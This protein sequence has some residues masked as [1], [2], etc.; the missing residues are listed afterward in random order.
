M[1][2]VVS[3]RLLIMALALALAP[4]VAVATDPP[5]R[6]ADYPAPIHV[7]SLDELRDLLEAGDIDEDQYDTL[8]DLLESP[9][10]LNGATR[11]ELYDL[12]GLTYS[13]VDV[14]IRFR[15]T[16]GPVVDVSDLGQ[17]G[18]P[19]SVIGQIRSFVRGKVVPPAEKPPIK[20]QANL[21]T[22]TPLAQ[23]A[24]PSFSLKLRADV[25]DWV[26]VGG[27]A[28]LQDWIGPF[29]VHEDPG[30][31]WISAAAPDY[32]FLVPKFFAAVQQPQWGVV[33]GTYQV[34]FA[35][36]L[37]VGDST[38][39]HPNG[40]YPDVEVPE[41]EEGERFSPRERL[42]GVAASLKPLQLGEA[43]AIE[44]TVFLSWWPYD[45]NQNDVASERRLDDDTGTFSN[46]TDKTPNPLVCDAGADPARCAHF[47]SDAE[48][49]ANPD[50]CGS[51][52]AG[53]L[54]AQRLR[55]AYTELAFGGHVAYTP[56]P[57]LRIGVSSMTSF[58]DW[59]GWRDSGD[60]DFTP[61]A[62]YPA[63]RDL[64][65][66]FGVD[67]L[68]RF[69][70]VSI[71]G[72][73]AHT[74]VGGNAAVL[75]ANVGFPS[76]D[77]ELIGRY[78]QDSFDNPHARG[79]AQSDEYQGQRDR[80]EAGGRVRVTAYPLPW[81]DA[82]L[83]LDVWHRMSLATTNLSLDGKLYL[84]PLEWLSIMTSVGYVDRDLTAGGRDEVYDRSDEVRDEDADIDE[85]EIDPEIAASAYDTTVPGGRGSKVAARLRL[86]FNPARWLRLEAGYRATFFDQ[87]VTLKAT[88]YPEAE[89]NDLH[90]F[91][92]K[93][94]ALDHWA[95]FLVRG[96]PHED[97]QLQARFKYLDDEARFD[98]RGESFIEGYLQAKWTVVP[99][100]YEAGFTMAVQLRYRAR[101]WID[102]RS[103]I[104]AHWGP[105]VNPEHLFKA[106]L[107][108]RF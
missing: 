30:K 25:L 60:L 93:N 42:M 32:R 5:A 24:H 19:H 44:G 14:I 20:G 9:L 16:R 52:V 26:E 12:P 79:T 90:R 31:T 68:A 50:A 39:T 56:I 89:R 3:R 6:A 107:E 57:Q 51:D 61:S 10:D 71:G 82:R 72:E 22:I 41:Y 69:A 66:A 36:R 8:A 80:D 15:E 97:L 86:Q 35:E 85:Y 70:N 75:R 103:S 17:L 27:V 81:L 99:K 83:D 95:Y 48:K 21:R 33:V 28:L 34:G 92:E 105:A 4:V 104:Q 54:S 76:I 101:Y 47:C 78:Y 74:Y 100:R 84:D 88:V 11:D 45:A 40:F 23:G 65:G 106:R 38:R 67:F 77:L 62:S 91:Y 2:S 73:Y 59:H 96:N 7:D 43:G 29:H 37:V 1:R 98:Y 55:G 94:Y 53:R 13:M 87:R 108:A 18:I 63:G 46:A 102:E 58:M 64:L 49:K